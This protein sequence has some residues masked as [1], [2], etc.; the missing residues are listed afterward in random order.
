MKMP[1]KEK[2]L[3][4][5]WSKNGQGFSEIISDTTVFQCPSTQLM[6]TL[7]MG[8]QIVAAVVLERTMALALVPKGLFALRREL[9]LFFPIYFQFYNSRERHRGPNSRVLL[10]LDFRRVS[11]S[12][13]QNH[14]CNWLFSTL[15]CTTAIINI[16]C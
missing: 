10:F 1:Q 4:F 6:C 5:H 8:H 16:E 9:V 12:V 15:F 13:S 11:N 2:V 3:Q 7:W 14:F